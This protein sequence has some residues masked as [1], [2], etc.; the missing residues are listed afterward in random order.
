MVLTSGILTPILWMAVIM[1]SPLRQLTRR[2]VFVVL[3]VL[4]LVVLSVRFLTLYHVNCG[5]DLPRH[6]AGGH[7]FW[8]KKRSTER[9]PR[10][11]TKIIEHAIDFLSEALKRRP[12]LHC[13]RSVF[14]F[15][16]GSGVTFSA[17][18]A[19]ITLLSF[20]QHDRTL[21]EISCVDA[22]QTSDL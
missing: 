22:S 11:P 12:R 4:T 10:T 21:P 3:G 7:W 13:Q 20:E 18:I 16:T 14:P 19:M 2:L 8:R 15:F 5:H 17:K 6:S 9:R 1:F